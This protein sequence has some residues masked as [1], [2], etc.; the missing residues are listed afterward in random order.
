MTGYLSAAHHGWAAKKM[1]DSRCSKTTILAFLNPFGKPFKSQP[2]S[3]SGGF[4]CF[5]SFTNR[6]FCLTRCKFLTSGCYFYPWGDL[7]RRDLV[8]KTFKKKF[9]YLNHFIIT[10]RYKFLY[11]WKE[12][13]F[14]ITWLKFIFN[15]YY[16]FDRFIGKKWRS[17]KR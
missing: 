17:F 11:W 2:F 6:T 16:C 12:L 1:F 9:S 4:W 15:D 13:I 3:T 10:S 5:I 14:G 8:L 7:I